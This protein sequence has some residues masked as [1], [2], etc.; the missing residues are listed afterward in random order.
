MKCGDQLAD[1]SIYA[2]LSSAQLL[3][4]LRL[5]PRKI[6]DLDAHSSIRTVQDILLDEDMQRI[7]GVPYIGPVWASRI[8]NADEEF[9]SV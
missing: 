1:T 9:V 3:Q 6:Q 2:D 7:R 8:R 5:T 4:N